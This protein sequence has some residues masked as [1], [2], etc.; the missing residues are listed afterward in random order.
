MIGGFGIFDGNENNFKS[1]KLYEN[2]VKIEYK[3]YKTVQN[4][5]AIVDKHFKKKGKNLTNAISQEGSNIYSNSQEF[6]KNTKEINKTVWSVLP[7]CAKQEIIRKYRVDSTEMQQ[8]EMEQKKLTKYFFQY[9][10]PEIAS[11]LINHLP[12]K[13][14]DYLQP[15][16]DESGKCG[17]ALYNFI[18]SK[19]IEVI[20]NLNDENCAYFSDAFKIADLI[21]EFQ[22]YA[23][24]LFR[25][26]SLNGNSYFQNHQNEQSNSYLKLI[27][28]FLKSE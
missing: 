13:F 10:L 22:K 9:K 20:E 2:I 11:N 7:D 6:C 14:H 21:I 27:S 18:Q 3:A 12:G 5:Y 23:F 24:S 26:N 8:S 25:S 28:D 4:M 1:L 17:Y 16:A 15:L 19:Q